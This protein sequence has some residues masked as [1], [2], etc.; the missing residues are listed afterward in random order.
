MLFR[1]APTNAERAPK[2]FTAEK[3]PAIMKGYKKSAIMRPKNKRLAYTYQI[4]FIDNSCI[5]CTV[6]HDDTQTLEAIVKLC[7]YTPESIE[8]EYGEL[9]RNCSNY[10]YRTETSPRY[11]KKYDQIAC[12][13]HGAISAGLLYDYTEAPA[14]TQEAPT[15]PAE[16]EGTETPAEATRDAETATEDAP[17]VSAAY[18]ER[19]LKEYGKQYRAL[20]DA[21]EN[22]ATAKGAD[23]K[24]REYCAWFDGYSQTRPAILA[25]YIRLEGDYISSDREAA[26]FMLALEAIGSPEEITAAAETPT[27]D[28][29][30]ETTTPPAKST[31]TATETATA[32]T[33]EE[34][35]TKERRQPENG[36]TAT[37]APHTQRTTAEAPQRP[38]SAPSHTDTHGAIKSPYKAKYKAPP[39]YRARNHERRKMGILKNPVKCGAGSLKNDFDNSS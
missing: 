20:Y 7:D 18:M 23:N 28:A 12:I 33:S 5:V 17:R 4:D 1:I 3:N 27:T 30:K 34:T 10:P 32:A 38:A 13:V 14:A 8:V 16:D 21:E 37:T 9:Y 29:D 11:L 15:T 19:F 26:A 31:Q 22:P 36:T 24:R 2:C 25:E 39:T 35:P 6:R